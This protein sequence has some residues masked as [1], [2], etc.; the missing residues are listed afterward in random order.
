[1]NDLEDAEPGDASAA[2]PVDAATKPGE[3]VEPVTDRPAENTHA[4]A[5]PVEA[6]P[7]DAAAPVN[8]A[9][10]VEA[11]TAVGPGTPADA[12]PPVDAATPVDAG[13][14]PL[15]PIATPAERAEPV[16]AV[17]MQET[18]ARSAS[19]AYV[20]AALICAVVGLVIPVLPAAAALML[21]RA[22]DEDLAGEP[23][24]PSLSGV[25]SFAR[26]LAWFDLAWMTLLTVALL[27]GILGRVIG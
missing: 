20:F 26:G 3:A 1:M 2:Q 7:A 17:E 27:L 6:T 10:A 8:A 16:E 22:T 23:L 24:R 15:E 25:A 21:L 4:A 12:A 19:D 13:P 18:P 11:G 14:A 9:A 5:D